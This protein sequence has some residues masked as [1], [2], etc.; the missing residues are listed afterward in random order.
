MRTVVSTPAAPGSPQFSQAVVAGGLVFVSGMTGIDPDTG[1]LAGPDI[2][3]QTARALRNCEAILQAAGAGLQDVVEVQVLLARSEDF[4]GMGTCYAAFF[5]HAPPARSVARL[6]V[7]IPGVL[8]SIRMV[9]ALAQP[10][11]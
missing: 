9:A 2:Q 4:A 10:R 3:A 8:V 7:E 6:G 11:G 1:Q 5:P